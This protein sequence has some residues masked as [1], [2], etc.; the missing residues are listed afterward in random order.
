MAAISAVQKD[1]T[2]QQNR[3]ITAPPDQ[4]IC[5]TASPG[6]GKT[7]TI[8]MRIVH[9]SKYFKVPLSEICLLTYNRSLAKD[10]IE[11]L[12]LHGISYKELGWCGTLHALCYRDTQ[13]YATL[14]PWIEKFK[15]CS[16]VYPAFKYIIFDE[17]Q[18]ADQSIADVVEILSRNKYLTII[19][20]ERQQKRLSCFAS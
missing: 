13:K 15:D 17:Y 9:I 20:D 4:N 14:T 6:A 5:I 11:K 16:E 8:I 12:K 1:V 19:G 7:T 18:D 3:I 10:V 2:K